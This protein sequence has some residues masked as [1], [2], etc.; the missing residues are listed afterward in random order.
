MRRSVKV[1]LGVVVIAVAALSVGTWRLL[2]VEPIP[3]V[4]EPV[5]NPASVRIPGVAGMQDLVFADLHGQTTFFVMVGVQSWTSDEG[6][7]LNRAVNRWV[8]PES[9]KGYIIFDAEGLGLFR[10]KA[11]K[12]MTQFGSETRFPMY[13]DFEGVFRRAL[14]LPQGHH[15]FAVIGPE[16]DVVLRKSGGMSDPGEVEALRELLGAVEPPPGP[17]VPDFALAGLSDEACA[18]RPCALLFL[19]DTVARGDVPKIDDGFEGEDEERWA[20]MDKPHVR[21]VANA[22]KLNLEGR[23]LGVMVGTT[24]NLDFPGW[25]RETSASAVRGAFGVATDETSLLV[26]KD[27]KIAFAASGKIPLFQ[28]GQVSDLLGVEFKFDD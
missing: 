15:G 25:K 11:T 20:Q 23:A 19:G 5:E 3:E 26:L 10:D 22:L 24:E 17:A 4:L 1:G 8:L 21:A 13:G 27:G 6:R 7:G 9:S 28:L 18:R 16:G 2:R 14:K 12:Y